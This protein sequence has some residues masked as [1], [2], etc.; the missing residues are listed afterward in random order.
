[1]AYKTSIEKVVGRT[2]TPLKFKAYAIKDGQY[3]MYC[4]SKQ[5][6]KNKTEH[7]EDEQEWEFIAYG[8]AVYVQDVI[9][10]IES[11][12]QTLVLYFDVSE[13]MR[14]TVYFPRIDLNDTKILGLTTYGVQVTKQ[15]ADVLI[16]VLE[17]QEVNA[18]RLLEHSSL[19][20]AEWNGQPIFKG[21]HAV[22]VQ[23]NYN[24]KMR[25]EP[26]GC[27]DKWFNMVQEEVIGNI[28]LE[29]MLAV[30]V[31]GMLV[32]Y[33]KC[34][35]NVEN[36]LCH[37]IGESSSGKTTAALL[38]VSMGSAPDFMGNNFVF[39]FSDTM[40]S[41]MRSIPSSYPSM[42]DEG[43]LIAQN[44]DM[45]TLLYS[46]SSGVEKRRL[47]AA[48][49]VRGTSRFCTAIAMTS[50]KSILSQC[51]QNTGLLIRNIEFDNVMWTKSAQ[52]SDRIKSVL[53]NNY[54]HLVPMISEFIM[55]IGE[56]KI[57]E[58]LD[59]EVSLFV[60]QAKTEGAYNKLTERTAKQY[61]LIVVGVTI[62]NHV[63]GK[64]FHK[65]EVRRFLLEHS[66]IADNEQVSIGLRAMEFLKYYIS[67]YKLQFIEE[68][69]TDGLSNCK[70]R[71]QKTK[72]TLLASGETS[73][74]RLLISQIE[75]EKILY[76]GKF[77]DKNIVLR[78]LKELGY[79]VCQKDRYVSKVKIL[80]NIEVIGY[81]IQL[82]TVE[83]TLDRT[84]LHKYEDEDDLDEGDLD[85]DE[86]YDESDDE[87][88]DPEDDE[89]EA[90]KV[91]EEKVKTSKN[92][93]SIQELMRSAEEMEYEE[94][95]SDVD[96]ED[97]KDIDDE[98]EDR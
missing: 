80:N 31:A 89:D 86:A 37:L 52:S 83:K 9:T 30:G 10:E 8:G 34:T 42:I 77:S 98:L 3:G 24:G 79:L 53:K 63:L 84:K 36:I 97:E 51:N 91:E 65:K 82:P 67:K 78:E 85:D 7:T 59:K 75:F 70:G 62:L 73:T 46:L 38:M 54:G 76:E 95:D 40:N 35:I 57:L 64:I 11:L 32:D 93:I 27:F 33:L 94:D 71:L 15:S 81:I 19:G 6:K 20:F 60:T 22:G 45:T 4:P 61:G 55:K 2:T 43:S 17:N 88:F 23:S 87:S 56:D 44:K 12:K 16:K 14:Q 92:R 69:G 68:V 49:E 18:K 66:L 90:V 47:S 96:Y 21:A 13:D 72:E 48:M 41:L 29:T 39:T 74:L 50:E 58:R 5:K 1:M 28:P 25:I 26:K